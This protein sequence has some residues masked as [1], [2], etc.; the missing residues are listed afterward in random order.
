MNEPAMNCYTTPNIYNTITPNNIFSNDDIV[1]RTDA[2]PHTNHI[3]H[4]N[5]INADSS[6]A[7]Q[8]RENQISPASYPS[9]TP[10][11]QEIQNTPQKITDFASDDS[12]SVEETVS[13]RTVN[14]NKNGVGYRC[15]L[16]G[17]DASGNKFN[18]SNYETDQ[19]RDCLSSRLLLESTDGG[20][21]EFQVSQGIKVNE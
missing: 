7:C 8:V 13:Q 6:N 19:D 16:D 2:T 18:K 12:S 3:P 21:L 15:L 1:L 9:H 5:I 17:Y 11:K 10:A 4:S 20:L 14:L